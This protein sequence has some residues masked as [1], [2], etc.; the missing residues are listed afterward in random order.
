MSQRGSGREELNGGTPPQTAVEH[1][2]GTRNMEGHQE[3]DQK[4]ESN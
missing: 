4:R 1:A 3:M 2:G